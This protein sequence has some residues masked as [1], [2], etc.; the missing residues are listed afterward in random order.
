MRC[1][2]TPLLM[3]C[4]PVTYCSRKNGRCGDRRASRFAHTDKAAVI[5]ARQGP[6]KGADIGA[7]VEEA[8][9]IDLDPGLCRE[10]TVPITPKKTANVLR[11]NFRP[12]RF[13]Q[14]C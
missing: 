3:R 14:S 4:L 12:F 9:G 11:K 8:D 2:P 1:L 10:R 13:P 7:L 6:E 5:L